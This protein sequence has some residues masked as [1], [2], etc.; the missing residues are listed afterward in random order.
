MAFSKTVTFNSEFVQQI[1]NEAHGAL[2]AV[3]GR[4]SGFFPFPTGGDSGTPG[5][6]STT[7][8]GGSTA[9][10]VTMTLQPPAT[11]DDKRFAPGG[12]TTSFALANGV[13]LKEDAP[14]AIS[15]TWID[16]P[17]TVLTDADPLTVYAAY[18]DSAAAPAF[19]VARQS[20]IDASPQTSAK[21]AFYDPSTQTWLP[22]AQ[23]SLGGVFEAAQSVLTTHG[24]FNIILAGPQTLQVQPGTI[25]GNYG[26]IIN[27]TIQLIPTLTLPTGGTFRKDLLVVTDP[28][29]EADTSPSINL[30]MGSDEFGTSAAAVAAA[31]P[32]VTVPAQVPLAEIIMYNAGAGALGVLKIIDIRPIQV[33]QT[34]AMMQALP[35]A[36][37]QLR[38]NC[39]Q[40]GIALTDTTPSQPNK[41]WSVAVF[42]GFGGG[43]FNGSKMVFGLVGPVQSRLFTGPLVPGAF[44]PD[45]ASQFPPAPYI[46]QSSFR[47]ISQPSTPGA[48]DVTNDPLYNVRFDFLNGV[49]QAGGIVSQQVTEV[50]Q[51]DFQQVAALFAVDEDGTIHLPAIDLL[52]AHIAPTNPAAHT[53]SN[54]AYN[55]AA[56]PIPGL[57]NP[58]VSVQTAIAALATAAGGAGGGS[59][60]AKAALVY[61]MSGN[62]NTSVGTEFFPNF[63]SGLVIPA[64]FHLSYVTASLG[65]GKVT[66]L[67]ADLGGNANVNVRINPPIPASGGAVAFAVSVPILNPVSAIIAYGNGS[68]VQGGALVQGDFISASISLPNSSNPA[69]TMNITCQLILFG[70]FS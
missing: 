67:V 21:L 49:F 36:F 22:T 56:G 14:V 46:L 35:Q 12:Q 17:G 30:L 15:A 29:D 42:R 63:A 52:L 6:S 41:T 20:V 5:I 53:S 7:I 34:D 31:A 3:N 60:G 1:F 25:I 33:W 4:L 66:G 23:I 11:A 48:E 57:T 43:G 55:N 37:S 64:G 70:T 51:T 10:I 16:P 28:F 38:V 44:T 18:D 9:R 13:V 61:S 40:P 54:I 24:G 19:A 26:R 62:F 27:G 2:W 45:P 39:L 65:I 69:G 32:R 68:L 47:V 58:T 59:S 50:F 8:G